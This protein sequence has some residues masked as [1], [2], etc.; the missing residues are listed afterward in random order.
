VPRRKR[1]D[2]DGAGRDL[3]AAEA[4]C[5]DT[6]PITA[7]ERLHPY[8]WINPAAPC[9]GPYGRAFWGDPDAM[10]AWA[11]EHARQYLRSDA[12]V[13]GERKRRAASAARREDA[14]P[15]RVASPDPNLP[16]TNDRRVPCGAANPK[17]R[18]DEVTG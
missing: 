3:V 17:E 8:V 13:L 11:E 1:R 16:P 18:T 4:G 5:C 2:A 10:L 12:D 14:A 6:G 7:A 9:N 15:R